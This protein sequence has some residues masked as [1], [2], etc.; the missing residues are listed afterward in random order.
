MPE[1]T[2]WDIQ[3]AFTI[4]FKGEKWTRGPLAGTWKVEPAAHPNVVAWHTPNGGH[5]SEIEAIRFKQIGV[6]AGIPDY[7]FLYVGSLYALEFKKPGGSLSEAQSILHPR[8]RNAGI[9]EL[10][11]VDNIVN[12]K[13]FVRRHGLVIA[14]R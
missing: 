2:E 9:R 6:E 11:T 10:S 14:G 1:I 7:F 12:A 5:R 13:N 8:L 3:R 4:W